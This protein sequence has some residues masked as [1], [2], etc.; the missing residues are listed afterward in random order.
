MVGDLLRNYLPELPIFVV[1]DYALPAWLPK[2]TL[3]FSSSYSGNTEE[4]LSMF[5]DA[6]KKG[7]TI[8]S[9]SSGG[10]LQRMAMAKSLP[11]VEL[12]P[13]FSP[14]LT[15]GFMLIPLI[16]ILQQSGIISNR[17][18]HL[19]KAIK[20]LQNPKHRRVGEELSKRLVEKL[21]I[22]YASERFRSVSMKWKTDINETAKT[23]AFFNTYSE[24]N[25][26]EIMGF[27]EQ[28]TSYH[29]IILRDE[30]DPL[31]IVKRMQITN[32]L[33]RETGAGVTEIVIRGDNMLS[34]LLSTVHIGF[35]MSYFLAMEYGHDPTPVPI[36]ESLKNEL[37]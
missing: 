11:H 28:N 20:S 26:N 9:L 18:A 14:R 7:F 13:G 34:K 10:K 15:T 25:H 22:I 31:R 1:R 3:V 35:W 37:K 6:H 16:K 24:M 4:T 27:V 12:P 32:K 29:V 2:K 17:D 5:Q 30:E 36:I 33:M 8:I 23:H 21:P 19:S